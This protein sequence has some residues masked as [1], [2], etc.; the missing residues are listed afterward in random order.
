MTCLPA[1]HAGA[2]NYMIYI[3]NSHYKGTAYVGLDVTVPV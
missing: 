1:C 2:H 3:V